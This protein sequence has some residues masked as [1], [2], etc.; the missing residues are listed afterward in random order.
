M[1]FV[2]LQGQC[3]R[4]RPV[5]TPFLVELERESTDQP[6]SLGLMV[7]LALEQALVERP[8]AL[9]EPLVVLV[10]PLPLVEQALVE[11]LVVLVVPL[12]LVVAK[13]ASQA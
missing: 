13:Q 7:P 11:P 3:D 10:V 1:R 2:D 5:A 12:A 4:A 8:L 6:Q 9:V